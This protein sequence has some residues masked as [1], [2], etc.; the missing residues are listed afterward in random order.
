MQIGVSLMISDRRK[1]VV[2]GV[3]IIGPIAAGL[4]VLTVLCVHES[5][6]EHP[7]LDVRLFRDPRLSPAAA[8]IGL[9]F[10]AMA[11]V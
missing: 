5:R 10:F 3:L 8:A 6:T 1:R 2:L 4:A 7:S 9:N 11:G